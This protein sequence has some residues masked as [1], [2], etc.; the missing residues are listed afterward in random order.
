MKSPNEILKGRKDVDVAH[1]LVEVLGDCPWEAVALAHA[2]IHLLDGADVESSARIAFKRGAATLAKSRQL[3]A[4]AKE[5]G[6]IG[7]LTPRKRTGSAENPVTK[8]FP[9]S[10]TEQRFLEVLEKLCDSR[11]ELDY[12]DERE[13]GHTL[14]DFGLSEKGIDLPINVKVVVPASRNLK[15]L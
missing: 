10:V 13:T 15:N 2:Y 4:G 1:A 7:L 8:L 12:S 14:T 3:V 9:A 6:F 5:R 11:R